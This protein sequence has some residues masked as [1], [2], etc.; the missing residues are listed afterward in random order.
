MDA[1]VPQTI[2]LSFTLAANK[3]QQ[4]EAEAVVV[5]TIGSQTCGM[6]PRTHPEKNYITLTTLHY[7]NNW[8]IT[9]NM[10][11]IITT[12]MAT[13]TFIP[14]HKSWTPSIT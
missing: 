12:T 4:A 10:A 6:G 3:A 2:A 8:L 9:S 5:R 11:A 14:Q 7:K 13:L 1:D